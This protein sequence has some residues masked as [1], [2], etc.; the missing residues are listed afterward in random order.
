VEQRLSCAT[1]QEYGF[2]AQIFLTNDGYFVEGGSIANCG[3]G[4]DTH[5]DFKPVVIHVL[6]AGT[7][8]I[9]SGE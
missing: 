7:W 3:E 5:Q 6:N 2:C 1:D 8:E 4:L 9:V